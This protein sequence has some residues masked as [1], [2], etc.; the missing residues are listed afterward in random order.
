MAA[1]KPSLLKPILLIIPPSSINLNNLFLGFP[2]CAFGVTVPI[3][4]KPKPKSANSLYKTAF[5]SKPAA[6]PTGF[7]NFKPK[8]SR[9]RRWSSIGFGKNNRVK[10]PKFFK[11]K[12]VKW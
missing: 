6:K 10:K 3:S 9:S 12:K 4:T 1:S 8:T 7:L 5:L 11:M 2:D